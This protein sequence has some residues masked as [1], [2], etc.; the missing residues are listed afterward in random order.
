MGQQCGEHRGVVGL[1]RT[2]QDHQWSP[3]A[4]DELVD[5]G[6]ESATRTPH[7]VIEGLVVESTKYVSGLLTCTNR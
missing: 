6:R 7:S 3:T 2:G 4:I 1:A 5:L